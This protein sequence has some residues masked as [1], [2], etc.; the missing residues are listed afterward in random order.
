[1]T[2]F[3]RFLN[4]FRRSERGSATLE[5]VIVFPIFVVLMGSSWELGLITMR[6]TIIERATDLVVRDIRLGTGSAPQHDEIKQEI[7]DMAS[8][9]TNCEQNLRIEMIQIDP[10]NWTEPPAEADCTDASQEVSPVRAFENG[11]ENELMLL[12]VCFKVDPLFPAVGL[13]KALVTDDAGQFALV[14]AAAFV[15]EPL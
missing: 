12:R 7:C 11:Q 8:I 6:T 13:G 9:L 3:K 10:R 14:A 4:R 1:M 15:Q 5:F 2:M